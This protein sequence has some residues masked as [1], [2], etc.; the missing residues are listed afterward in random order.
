[1]WVDGWACR[2]AVPGGRR[3]SGPAARRGRVVVELRL[4]VS[5]GR[6]FAEPAVETG[7]PLEIRDYLEVVPLRAGKLDS[8]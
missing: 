7:V 4:P 2:P 3:E 1:M 6:G 8:I 5:L